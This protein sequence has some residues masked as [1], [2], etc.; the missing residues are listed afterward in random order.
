MPRTRYLSLNQ[1]SGRWCG[2]ESG[3]FPDPCCCLCLSNHCTTP[4]HEV[5]ISFGEVWDMSLTILLHK[6]R[7]MQSKYR[8]TIYWRI[9]GGTRSVLFSYCKYIAFI[10]QSHRKEK[11]LPSNTKRAHI[12]KG[13]L[14]RRSP[15]TISSS[16]TSYLHPSTSPPPKPS[17]EVPEQESPTNNSLGSPPHHRPCQLLP[18][19]PPQLQ[20]PHI[21]NSDTYPCTCHSSSPHLCPGMLHCR[22]PLS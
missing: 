8:K 19:P 22:R 7:R 17:L 18:T 3:A 1:A 15:T 16:S 20:C 21:A 13:W 2:I 6:L 14:S 12:P 9:W 11:S 5:S 10:R 4:N